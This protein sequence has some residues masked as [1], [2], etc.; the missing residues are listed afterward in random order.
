MFGDKSCT[1]AG[2]I[3]VLPNQIAVH[4]RDK[5]IEAEVDVFHRAVQFCGVVVAQVFGVLDVIDVALR[6]DERATRLGH[7]FAVHGE[8]AV[9][10]QFG[11]RA[12]TGVLQHRGP[13]QRV[14]I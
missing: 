11:R 1:A 12:E 9:R 6:G 4:L 2:N 14:K 3:D 5:I 13:E 8:E 10:E 7:F